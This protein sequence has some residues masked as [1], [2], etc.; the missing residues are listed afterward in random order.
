V[1]N[2]ADI[3]ARAALAE[4]GIKESEFKLF[5]VTA[6]TASSMGKMPAGKILPDNGVRTLGTNFSE[7]RTSPTREVGKAFNDLKSAPKNQDFINEMNQGL[8]G[9]AP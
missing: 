4:F 3:A 9:A 1:I 2:Y 5:G 7:G 6:S 8:I